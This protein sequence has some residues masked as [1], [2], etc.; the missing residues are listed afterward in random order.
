[1]RSMKQKVY[2]IFSQIMGIPMEDINEHSS[3][4][5]VEAW[6]SLK[7]MNLVLALE[8]SLNVQ[9]TDEQIVEMLSMEL[10]LATVQEIGVNP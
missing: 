1:M 7:H 8:E 4:D 2:E 6:D 5:T 10:I 9:F 3:P